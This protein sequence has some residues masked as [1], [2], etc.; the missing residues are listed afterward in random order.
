MEFLVEFSWVRLL[1]GLGMHLTALRK[2]HSS[3]EQSRWSDFIRLRCNIPRKKRLYF[4]I[5][6]KITLCYFSESS[7]DLNKA[8]LYSTQPINKD[9]SG[10]KSYVFECSLMARHPKEA[11]LTV[12][13]F[14]FFRPS[15]KVDAK[16]SWPQCWPQWCK[17]LVARS[18]ILFYS[19]I[20]AAVKI[21]N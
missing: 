8:K 1:P 5:C 17:F 18:F 3:P 9:K 6:V 19:V 20:C 14:S 15:H 21:R 11:S 7:L 12:V 16:V 4:T 10:F 13:T 2:W